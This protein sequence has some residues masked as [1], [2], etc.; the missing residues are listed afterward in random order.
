MMIHVCSL[1]RLAD[2]VERVGA[3]HVV[4]LINEGTPVTRPLSIPEQN[5][6]FLAMN[7][8]I[9]PI[10]GMTLPGEEHVRRLLD[11]VGG[12][13]RQAPLVVHCFAGISRS[14]A[15]AYTIVCALNPQRNETELA[16]TLRSRS[17]SA[18]PNRRIVEVA[19]RLLGRDGRMVAAIDA[20]GRGED[21]FEGTPFFLE[22]S[23]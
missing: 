5:H 12:W 15:A 19:D 21:A 3:S 1:P 17:P 18:T 11:W 10:E 7:D 4:T 2:T 14:T 20:I 6:L 9:E 8:I 22:L 13:D 23:R 16:R